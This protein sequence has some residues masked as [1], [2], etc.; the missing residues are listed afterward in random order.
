MKDDKPLRRGALYS[1]VAAIPALI[2]VDWYAPGYGL[3]VMFCFISLGLIFDQLARIY[4]PAVSVNRY[5]AYKKNRLLKMGA[6][7]LFVMSP[8]AL[9]YVGNVA[10]FSGVAVCLLMIAVGI[11]L[12][13]IARSRD[14][15][16][17]FW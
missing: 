8:M 5:Q 4:F 3:L 12:D 10:S 15:R 7:L 16:V 6:L 1:F 14:P 17:K 9:I 13:Q 11:C 2:I